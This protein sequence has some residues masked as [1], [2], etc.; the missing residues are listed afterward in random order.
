MYITITPQKLGDNYAESVSDF[1]AYLEKENEGKT[2]EDIE[3]FFNQYGDQFTSKEVIREIDGNT[4][5]L[6]KTEPKFYSITLNPSQYELKHL[7][8]QSEAL[9]HYTREA[10]KNYAASFHRDIEGRPISVDD[11][12]Y[13]AKIEHERTYKG[14]DKAIRENAPYYGK[15]VALRNEIQQIKSGKLMGDIQAKKQQIKRLEREAPHKVNGRMITQGMAK[16]GA[17]SHIH[18]IV[19]RKDQSNRYSLSPGSKY[20]ASEVVMNGKTVKRGFDRDTFIKN[21]EATF[22]RLFGYKRNYVETYQARK[23]LVTQPQQYYA[24]IMGLPTN[25]KAIGFKMLGKAGIN[26][27]LMNLPTNKAQLV[28]KAIKQLK[29][30]IGKAMESGSIGI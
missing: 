7:H 16:E 5:K 2:L 24:S 26:T 17:Q 13:Y 22:D 8:S 1:V 14:T 6:K 21:S 20:K 10:M 28:L 9:K 30:G 15:I 11:I 4:A 18:I 29:R 12:K 27:P 23:T 25:E 19:S 3:P